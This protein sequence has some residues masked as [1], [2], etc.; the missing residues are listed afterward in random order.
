MIPSGY[1]GQI[2]MVG[3]FPKLTDFG[4][5]AFDSAASNSGVQNVVRISCVLDGKAMNIGY[6]AFEDFHGIHD[7]SGEGSNERV[8]VNGRW[9]RSTSIAHVHQL[10]AHNSET[11]RVETVGSLLP[12]ICI[13]TLLTRIAL[14]IK[15]TPKKQ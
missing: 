6:K 2:V 12:H 13:V 8:R 15:K 7:D 3:Y 10:R 14:H 9:V 4:V 11:L 5:W 1:S